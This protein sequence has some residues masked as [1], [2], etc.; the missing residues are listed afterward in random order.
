MTIQAI[1]NLKIAESNQ[2][3]SRHYSYDDMTNRVSHLAVDTG[4]R[5][6]TQTQENLMSDLLVPPRAS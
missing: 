3:M 5:M 1:G 4:R 6:L 2:S